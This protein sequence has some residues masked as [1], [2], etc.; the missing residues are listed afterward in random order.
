MK[1]NKLKVRPRKDVMAA[2][3]AAEFAA[4]LACWASS[5][6]LSNGGAC[7]ETGKM[8]QDCLKQSV[9][10]KWR[11]NLG[12]QFYA[13]YYIE[14]LLTQGSRKAPARSSINYQLARFT[15]QI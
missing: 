2:P 7:A 8:L 15:K 4:M 10:T 6:D 3:C 13:H 12:V 9:S 1:I 14:S 11:R 5:S